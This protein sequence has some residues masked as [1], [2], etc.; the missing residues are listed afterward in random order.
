MKKVLVR[1]PLLSQSGYGNHAR[2][3]VRWLLSRDDVEVCAQ[4]LH[5]GVT[6]W[7]IDENAEDGLIGKIMKISVASM[8]TDVDISL[9]LIHI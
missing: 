2:Q 9:S 7:L 1:G 5:W 6:P 8:P 3:I 4:V